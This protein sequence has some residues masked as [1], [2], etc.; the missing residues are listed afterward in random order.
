MENCILRV[1]FDERR[2]LPPET[3]RMSCQSCMPN[4][5]MD[6]SMDYITDFCWFKVANSYMLRKMSGLFHY[7]YLEYCDTE[8]NDG[9]PSA[10][11]RSSIVSILTDYLLKKGNANCS[12]IQSQKRSPLRLLWYM[13][14]IGHD[15]IRPELVA[16]L[17]KQLEF[18]LMLFLK[19]Q[20]ET[21]G[22]YLRKTSKFFEDAYKVYLQNGR[23][24]VTFDF[25]ESV[26]TFKEAKNAQ[27]YLSQSEK[28]EANIYGDF[29]AHDGLVI[30]KDCPLYSWSYLPLPFSVGI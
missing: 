20:G 15:S 13:V 12:L 22:F 6:R 30:D 27:F 1:S 26:L 3:I 2:F 5:R 18:C 24:E 9:R 14:A 4:L 11:I 21:Y 25:I 7:L 16:I 19:E 29:L 10:Q 8:A 23:G 28:E 17:S